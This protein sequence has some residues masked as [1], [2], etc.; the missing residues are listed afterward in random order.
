[1]HLGIYSYGSLEIRLLGPRLGINR[2]VIDFYLILNRLCRL[3]VYGEVLL[4]VF[5]ELVFH[6]ALGSGSAH[7]W[8]G[9]CQRHGCVRVLVYLPSIFFCHTR[10]EACLSLFQKEETH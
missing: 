4:G 7:W 5:L 10:L 8:R 3:G 9:C 6:A 1:M 2:H